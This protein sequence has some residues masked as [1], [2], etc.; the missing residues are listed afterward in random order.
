MTQELRE[1]RRKQLLDRCAWFFF[2]A[3]L[4][5]FI[6]IFVFMVIR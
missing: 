1:Q 3:S 4:S 6:T 5:N 2:G